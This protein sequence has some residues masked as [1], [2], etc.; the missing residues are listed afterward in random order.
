[1][2]HIKGLNNGDQSLLPDPDKVQ[3]R[4]ITQNYKTLSSFRQDSMIHIWD[5]VPVEN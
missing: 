5:E 1:M 4:S 3:I 2:I